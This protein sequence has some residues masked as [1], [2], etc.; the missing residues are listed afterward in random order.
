MKRKGSLEMPES[1]REMLV[2]R[3]DWKWLIGHASRNTDP[4]G[5]DRWA[6]KQTNGRIYVGLRTVKVEDQAGT[7]TFARIADL[8]CHQ[9]KAFGPTHLHLQDSYSSDELNSKFVAVQVVE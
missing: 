6:C 2:D 1:G 4:N 7:N 3:D 5:V 9:C 8:Q